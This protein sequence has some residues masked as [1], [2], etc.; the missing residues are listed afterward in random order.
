[1]KRPVCPPR[2]HLERYLLGRL[3]RDEIEA[4]SRHM[5]DC[6]D[7]Q[8]MLD[9]VDSA[10]DNLVATI[11]EVARDNQSEAD[12]E[13]DELVKRAAAISPPGDDLRPGQSV[14]C[15]APEANAT[16]GDTLRQTGQYQLL[17]SLGHGGMGTVYKAL[18]PTLNRLVAI[19]MLPAHRLVNPQAIARFHREIEVVGK[20]D[21]P[22]IVRAYDAGSDGD[23]FFLVMEFVDGMDLSRLVRSVGR[24]SVAEACEVI[25]QAS[26]GLQHAHERGLVHRDIKP[27]NLML[28]RSGEV[29]VLDMGLARVC[30]GL[31]DDSGLT[32]TGQLM[33]T[34]DYLAPEQASDS[35]TADIRADIYSLGC[36]LFHL[37]TGRP[38]YA[39]QEHRGALDRVMAHRQQ[40]LPNLT[41]VRPGVP[42]EVAAVL[43]RMAAKEPSDR[44]ESPA[45][46]AAALEHFT[47]GCDLTGLLARGELGE[48]QSEEPHRS[49]VL[50]AESDRSTGVSAESSHAAVH[51][52]S[53]LTTW[54]RSK[55]WLFRL[56][57]ATLMAVVVTA[58]AIVV[59]IR[60][61]DRDTTLR[62]PD[63]TEIEIDE[64]GNVQIELPTDDEQ[65]VKPA[66]S[67]PS[68][69][70]ASSDADSL[71]AGVGE[72]ADISAARVRVDFPPGRFVPLE[73]GTPLS[74]WYARDTWHS[75]PAPMAE[76]AWDFYQPGT[77]PGS[78]ESGKVTFEVLSDGSVLLAV[79]NRWGGGGNRSGGWAE[80]LTSQEDFIS[81]GWK[82]YASPMRMLDSGR[83]VSEAEYTVYR[84]ESK[85]GESFTVRTEKYLT[86]ILLTPRFN[87]PGG[88]SAQLVCKG[89][90]AKKTPQ[91]LLAGAITFDAPPG[92]GRRGAN[93]FIIH[94]PSHWEEEGTT[95]RCEYRRDGTARGVIFIHPFGDGHV[96]VTAFPP[97]NLHVASPG[98]WPEFFAYIP[99]HASIL[100]AEFPEDIRLDA[101]G[102]QLASTLTADGS[103][104]FSVDGMQVAEGKV[105]AAEPL[106][107]SR[108]FHGTRL[109]EILRRGDAGI[110]V[111]PHDNPGINEL[112]NIVLGLAGHS[113]RRNVESSKQ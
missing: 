28:T 38:P 37:L 82:E 15:H 76:H 32:S 43:S 79:T 98:R 65:S 87:E 112:Q 73:I 92:D 19:K 88:E 100:Q 10:S 62:V 49:Q 109:P 8:T 18:H 111:G 5:A 1:M 93:G 53:A 67:E 78:V 35:R 24:L 34:V 69:D 64:E 31:P 48:A 56:A 106:E 66:D 54:R 23:C 2:E 108:D 81:Q 104:R 107:L 105:E 4:T 110:I 45:E 14:G 86:P 94:A 52:R 84:R 97:G 40:Q 99:R 58:C 7:C 72:S 17:A 80:E 101:R 22:N 12:R 29:K 30:S 50:A 85:A 89:L 26:L 68:D 27:S 60:K 96:V 83:N 11:R 75:F 3:T 41:T 95:W 42:N 51:R 21:H 91:G 70:L 13:F 77:E 71:T 61:G 9:T 113:A 44:Y 102:R 74:L 90:V 33:G 39:D 57:V 103:Y 6:Q 25:R 46:V 36:T 16:G 63:G 55:P 59:T 47:G 20:L